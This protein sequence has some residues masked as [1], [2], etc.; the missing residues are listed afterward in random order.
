[1]LVK[2]VEAFSRAMEVESKR[3]K[4]EALAK[5]KENGSAKMD[6]TKTIRNINSSRRFG[7]QNF[8]PL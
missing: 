4:R 8:P 3:V 7:S 1:M 5:E 2:K 6:D